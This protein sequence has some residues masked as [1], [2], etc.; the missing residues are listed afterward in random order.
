MD[1]EVYL[2]AVISVEFEERAREEVA[3]SKDPQYC[4]LKKETEI[5]NSFIKQPIVTGGTTILTICQ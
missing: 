4:G 5:S 1:K 2:K 3:W